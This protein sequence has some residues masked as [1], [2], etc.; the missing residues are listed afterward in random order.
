MEIRNKSEILIS[1]KNV[2]CNDKL[3][4]IANKLIYDQN[5][6]IYKNLLLEDI[7]S[8]NC[9][10][11]V[12][13]HD[14]TNKKVISLTLWKSA[15]NYVRNLSFSLLS[16]KSLRKK[17]WDDFN[18]RIYTDISVFE[19]FSEEEI[20][21]Y[22]ISLQN[23]IALQIT[24][25]LLLYY[26][27]DSFINNYNNLLIEQDKQLMEKQNK[28]SSEE[29]KILEDQSK[30]FIEKIYE[31]KR[32]LPNE[33]LF[34]TEAND[35][36]K[37]K[38]IDIDKIDKQN[39]LLLF[40]KYVEIDNYMYKLLT[41][42]FEKY[43]EI[44]NEYYYYDNYTNITNNDMMSKYRELG[45]LES[46]VTGKQFRGSLE[47]IKTNFNNKIQMIKFFL[48]YMPYVDYI[49][50]QTNFFEFFK[51][52]PDNKHMENEINNIKNFVFKN[53]TNLDNYKNYLQKKIKTIDVNWIDIFKQLL[54]DKHI[55]I[56]LYSCYWGRIEN[57]CLHKKTFG[58]LVR[59][60]PIFDNS[61][62]ICIIRNMELL[63]SD[64]DRN[65]Y[66]EWL[67]Y[68]MTIFNYTFDYTCAMYDTA[69]N[70]ATNKKT[71]M[72]I[73][74]LNTSKMMLS[75]F[76]IN[77]TTNWFITSKISE[78]M[79]QCIN[80]IFKKTK[81]NINKYATDLSEKM[82]E[83]FYN[84]SYGVDEIILTI[85][86]Q[87]Q[88]INNIL[89]AK[90]IAEIIPRCEMYIVHLEN[91]ISTHKNCFKTLFVRN[92]QQIIYDSKIFT[93]ICSLCYLSK[94]LLTFPKFD[95]GKIISKINNSS[96]DEY[97]SLKN[98]N[99]YEYDKF[100]KYITY[101]DIEKH[102]F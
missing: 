48:Q 63:T 53:I 41:F 35:P 44:F 37:I 36:T 62:D 30:K 8:I 32:I 11:K 74:E 5:I 25:L 47:R 90:E 75:S 64:V 80:D 81:V 20:N 70:Y 2:Q 98:D 26:I 97:K 7:E 31:L 15:A 49:R 54:T 94:E 4:F 68:D 57:E 87:S 33:P 21:K 71:H 91:D 92:K 10:F 39:M 9:N 45:Y 65:Y 77:K 17:Y 13:K 78:K 38:F 28:K 23:K 18:L 76:N 56:W 50:N 40:I 89:E 69:I 1:Q 29:E 95:G 14:Q 12:I 3:K 101:S 66:D 83:E 86:L 67:E 79:L 100:V 22:E 27:D 82:S 72:C 55:E 16:W 85:C 58:S 96:F 34:M 99:N 102:F 93:K 19:P 43:R 59:Y 61:V 42:I 24:F 46:Y 88:T 51:L 84:F 73:G 52:L 6:K 60:Q